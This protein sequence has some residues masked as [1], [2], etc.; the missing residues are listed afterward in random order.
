MIQLHLFTEGSPTE[1]SQTRISGTLSGVVDGSALT[2]EECCGE[3]K[4]L[5]GEEVIIESAEERDSLTSYQRL[6]GREDDEDI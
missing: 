6:E 4:F 5:R 3:E 1:I 2:V